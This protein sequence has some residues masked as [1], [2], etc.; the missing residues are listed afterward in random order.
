VL[1]NGRGPPCGDETGK[2]SSSPSTSHEHVRQHQGRT[3]LGGR[4]TTK[5]KKRIGTPHRA[6]LSRLPRRDKSNPAAP[7]GPRRTDY[8]CRSASREGGDKTTA[9]ARTCP[10]TRRCFHPTP[11]SLHPPIP[12]PRPPCRSPSPRFSI[13]PASPPAAADLRAGTDWNPALPGGAGITA[14]VGVHRGLVPPRLRFLSSIARRQ[15]SRGKAS[16]C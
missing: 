12:A 1:S 13:Q 5:K 4:T 2:F 16:T 8:L 7:N 3:P 11:R 9:F 14:P 6:R 10:C 15:F